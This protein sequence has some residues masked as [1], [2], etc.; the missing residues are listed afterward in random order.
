MS[1][2][3]VANKLASE[4]AFS[5]W[6]PHTLKKRDRI[7]GAV[8]NRFKK[9]SHKF[10]I[11][12]PTSVK[13]A[14]LLDKE[15]GTT[16]WYDAIQKEMKNVRIAFDIKQ[17]ATQVPVGYKWIPCHMILDIKMDMTRKARYVA[18]GHVTDPPSASTYASVVSRES[19]RIAFMIAALND[20]DLLTADI[21]NAYLNAPVAEKVWTNCG[22]EFGPSQA[23]LPAVIV[24]SLY[25]LKSSGASFRNHLAMCMRDLGYE[26][27]LADAD[28]WMKR[29]K[30]SDGVDYYEYVL[31]Y[32]DDILVISENPK[33]TLLRLG[34]YFPLKKGSLGTP[35]TYLGAKVSKMT[36][37]NGVSSW[38]L[39]SSQ[40]CQEAV[41]NVE[42]YLSDRGDAGLSAK[43]TAPM[44]NGYRPEID[45][46]D[47]LCPERATYYQSVIGVLRWT[48]ELGRVDIITEVSM[49]SSHL[50]LPREGHL[51]AVFHVFAYLKKK[52]NARMFFDPTYP[53]ID[54]T[55]FQAQDW[56]NA[57]GNVEEA[58][59]PNAPEPLGKAVVMQC[60]VDADHAADKLTRRSRTGIL[61]F[62]NMAPITWFSKRQNSVETSTF[63][64][65]FC[66][67]KVA[68]EMCRGLRYK[69][70]MM[71]I[72]LDGAT[73]MY[74]DNNSV[75]CNTTMPES[76]LKKKSNSI[77]YHCVREA[78]AMREIIITYEPTDTNVSD[79]MTKALPGGERRTT[80]VRRILYDI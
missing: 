67:C 77:A 18:G 56:S 53:E 69:L 40:Y 63:G 32:T 48:I 45:M 58:I 39:S 38:G 12:L 23:G 1:E 35:D 36:L 46:S 24:R 29:A 79:L 55:R 59:P 65:E 50:A 47:E 73:Y 22:P 78:V 51:A 42:K 6:V 60:Y 70:R 33:E 72:P 26:S 66:A 43:A 64:S 9:K 7:I 15:T 37:P 17:D 71:G 31:I 74:C 28:V 20:L 44:T 27:C 80:L 19:V 62:L 54:E 61:I 68:T 34:K 11:E 57:Y 21:Q 75:V 76:T 14:L 41:R 52:H 10:G 30:R 16:F 49:L 3:A 8:N 5:W 25:G 2:Y 13:A 4:P